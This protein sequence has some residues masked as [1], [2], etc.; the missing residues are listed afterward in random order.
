MPQIQVT[1]A[2]LRQKAQLLSQLNNNLNTQIGVLQ[3][4]ETNVCSK[5]EGDS[6]SAFHNAFMHDKQCMDA[7]KA[8]ID[9][10][11]QALEQI[12]QNYE[13]AEAQ[14]TQTATSRSY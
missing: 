5:W 4:T 7:F 14:N 2:Q 12:A 10:Y 11:V 8:A 13:K 3:T 6:K 9:R 1:P